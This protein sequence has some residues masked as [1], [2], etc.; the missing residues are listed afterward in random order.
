M[1]MRERHAFPTDPEEC[2]QEECIGVVLLFFF[3]ARDVGLWQ[4]PEHV[5]SGSRSFGVSAERAVC[6]WWHRRVERRSL[7]DTR[8][9]RC[10]LS[11]GEH[12]KI[13]NINDDFRFACHELACFDEWCR[14][15]AGESNRS[16]PCLVFLRLFFFLPPFWPTQM[17]QLSNSG[18][19]INLSEDRR[20]TPNKLWLVMYATD[21]LW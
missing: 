20:T 18:S 6:A 3:C 15:S 4:I 1:L 8:R 19:H 12:L 16:F 7:W 17:H 5:S 10:R 14:S 13:N 2:K 21:H 11:S 9:T